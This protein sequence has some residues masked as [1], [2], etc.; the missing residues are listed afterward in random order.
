MPFCHN[1]LSGHT[2]RSTDGTDDS[3]TPLALTLA[4]LI[5]NDALIIAVDQFVYQEIS[6]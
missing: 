4:I 5:E 3:S 1:T 2:D 6:Q